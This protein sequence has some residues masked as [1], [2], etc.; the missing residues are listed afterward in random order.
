[1]TRTS[2]R[3]C[4]RIRANALIVVPEDVERY[5]AGARVEVM[6]LE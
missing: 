5:E 4:W 1:M 3:P 6:R 2:W